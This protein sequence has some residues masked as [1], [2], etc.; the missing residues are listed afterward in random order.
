MA[1]NGCKWLGMCE[2]GWSARKWLE[3]MKIAR[4]G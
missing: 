1:E 3:W 2:N 4:N